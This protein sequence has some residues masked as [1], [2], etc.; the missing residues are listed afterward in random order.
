MCNGKTLNLA[1]DRIMFHSCNRQGC[2]PVDVKNVC[3]EFMF[4]LAV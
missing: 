4:H 3:S 2:H 1:L